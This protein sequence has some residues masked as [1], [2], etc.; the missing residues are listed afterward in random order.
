MLGIMADQVLIR[1][2]PPGGGILGAERAPEPP[3][4]TRLQVL[5]V[6][7]L[8]L[9]AY[10]L[11][12]QRTF[13]R[14]DG[15]QLIHHML[16]KGQ[17]YHDV[18]PLYLP[19]LDLA[20]RLLAWT[21]QTAHGMGTLLSAFSVA[22]A[23]FFLGL[24]ARR[25]LRG[26]TRQLLFLAFVAACPAVS[27][28]ATVVEF[29]GLFFF[30]VGLSFCFAEGVIQAGSHRKAIGMALLLGLATSL[31]T[32]A[33]ATGQLLLPLFWGW[34][35]ARRSSWDRWPPLLLFSA[36]HLLLYFGG[37]ALLLHLLDIGGQSQAAGSIGHLDRWLRQGLGTAVTRF[38]G[39]FWWEIVY[40]FLPLSLLPLVLVL[41]G[42]RRARPSPLQ[43]LAAFAMFL[44]YLLLV[45][46]TLAD[47]HSGEAIWERGA[48]LLPL[49]PAAA[50][51][52][53]GARLSVRLFLVL[54]LSGAILSVTQI[55]SH[56][57]RPG[58]AFA[59]EIEA[60][61]QGAPVGLLVGPF[62]SIY[63]HLEVPGAQQI[64]VQSM[65][66]KAPAEAL[67]DLAL[68]EAR[69]RRWH[70]EGRRIFLSA[71]TRDLMEGRG[72]GEIGRRLTE[73][74]ASF[75]QI[76]AAWV[77]NGQA[78]LSRLE[79]GWSLVVVPGHPR[80]YELRSR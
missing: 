3:S 78:L 65:L 69:L 63:L 29:H 41:P 55:R 40:P 48:Y 12:G 4:L 24:M 26:R 31:G 46:L 19:I 11:L 33:H 42:E 56:D 32:A 9:L 43:L 35:I 75:P 22:G 73:M 2:K 76:Y 59:I 79:D 23:I 1:E 17:L 77:A 54:V 45:V 60:M 34:V 13:Y 70:A 39:Q 61:G 72:E 49:A 38:P 67:A 74:K 8:A 14:E 10:V 68:M 57:Q 18:H 27:F 28:F 71:K 36:T 15:Y 52:L 66:A 64:L 37:L 5:A 44:P 80:Y 16:G 30:F 7:L 50:W 21:G 20:T 51:A 47:E 6:A 25:S 62:E 58:L 53:A